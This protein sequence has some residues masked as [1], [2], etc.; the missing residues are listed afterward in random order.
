[1]SKKT[2]TNPKTAVKPGFFR[3]SAGLSSLFARIGKGT[4][5]R[6]D[7]HAKKVGRSKGAITDDALKAYLNGSR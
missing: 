5:K 4:A 6:L 7:I 2:A 3:P 1:M